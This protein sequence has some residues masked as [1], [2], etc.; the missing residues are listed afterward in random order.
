[1][2]A[3]NS[4][5]TGLSF[6]RG[7]GGVRAADFLRGSVIKMRE[8]SQVV[9]LAFMMESDIAHGPGAFVFLSGMA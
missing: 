8:S 7:H 2:E 3:D 9:G 4:D 6:G 1:V 5:A